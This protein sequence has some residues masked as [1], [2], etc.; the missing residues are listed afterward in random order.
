MISKIKQPVIMLTL[1]Q[2]TKWPINETFAPFSINM[3]IVICL[4]Q[5]NCIRITQRQPGDW[6]FCGGNIYL[7]FGII[8]CGQLI[9]CR[10]C[11]IRGGISFLYLNETFYATGRKKYCSLVCFG[12]FYH[13]YVKLV[14]YLEIIAETLREWWLFMYSWC[15]CG[16]GILKPGL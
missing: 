9:Y 10:K 7:M 6:I 1:I 2:H 11:L 8:L 4:F 3:F 5:N 16:D 12:S 15:L 14:S 13:C